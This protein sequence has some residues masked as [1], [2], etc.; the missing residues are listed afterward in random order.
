MHGAARHYGAGGVRGLAVQV[1]AAADDHPVLCGLLCAVSVTLLCA[2][3]AAALRLSLPGCSCIAVFAPRGGGSSAC[4]W[5][6]RQQR[7]P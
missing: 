1:D 7:L 4:S 2:A 5:L 6:A 3:A